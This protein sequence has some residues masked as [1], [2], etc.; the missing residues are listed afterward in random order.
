MGK[1]K[2]SERKERILKA[3]VDEYIKGANPVSSGEIQAKHFQDISSA[4][5]RAELSTLED[6][7]YLI[8]PHTSAGRIPSNKAYK[9]YV[10]KFL[11]KTPLKKG[12]MEIINK[13]FASR[14]AGV[15]EVVRQT[16]KVISDVTN[17][18]SVIV[19]KNINKV[20][21]KEI[22]L[23]GLD[24]HSL[25]VIIITDS[26][27]I[28][29]KMVTLS[30][31]VSP[32]Y[33]NDANG[34][35]NKM[36]S[37][38]SISQVKNPDKMLDRELE[39]FRELFENIMLI[40]NSYREEDVYLEGTTKLLEFPEHGVDT[41]KSLL[42]ALE[43]KEHFAE[44][45]DDGQDIEFSV[46]IGKDESGGLEKCAIVTA[47]YKVNG[48]EIGHAGVIGPERM[49][50]S[51]VFSVLSYVGKT[52]ETIVDSKDKSLKDNNNTGGADGEE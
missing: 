41:A 23:V 13:S 11:V 33:V 36:F 51:K 3:V 42:T 46:K 32:I 18:T 52:F 24:E 1:E 20:K 40:F 21:I 26:G 19:L 25:L 34:L 45:I 30:T 47:K 7:G 10:E 6:M 9:L 5:I 39:D 27:I 22:K 50:Y 16:A 48:E 15:E 44:I 49:D 17:Y 37:G 35:L 29:D 2:L 31:V 8:Q 4:T 38:K 28:R 12:E 43:T 14:F